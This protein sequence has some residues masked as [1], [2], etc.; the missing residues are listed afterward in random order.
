M[1]TITVRR[2]GSGDEAALE[3]LA[4]LD[5]ARPLRG[6]ALIAES[7]GRMLAALPLRS[8]RPIADPF[9]PT[10]ELVA[11][12]RLRREQLEEDQEARPESASWI[13]RS[14]LRSPARA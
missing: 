3:K 9:E 1:R 10:A 14:L 7:G 2:S 8:G 12:L 6:P 13:R 4:A 11:L 5:S